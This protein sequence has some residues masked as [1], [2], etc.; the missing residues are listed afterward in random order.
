MSYADDGAGAPILLVHGWSAHGGFFENLAQRLGRSHRVLTLTLRAHPGSAQG[1]APLTIDTLADDIA[2]FVAGLDLRDTVALGWSMG[3]MALWAAMPRIGPRITALVVE[4]MGAT[5]VNDAAWSGGLAGGYQQSDVAAT[6][7]DA[8]TD[9]PAH[10]ARFAPKMFAPSVRRE[11]PDLVAWA[12][13]EMSAA[14]SEAMAC[15]WASMASQD[16]RT[17]L[18]A[19]KAP[20]LVVHGAASLIYSERAT[21]FVASAAPNCEHVVISGA[22]HV[23][24]LEA[25]DAFF[26]HV[27][28]FVRTTRRPE[29]KSGGVKS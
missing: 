23:P 22:G 8:R 3:A 14:N 10:V 12:T 25:P 19:I 26:H 7:A 16:F 1:S 4:D 11:K 17:A 29:L 5:L 21:Q 15:F 9:W 20:M 27:E 18:K 13:R 28:A 6:L 24:H 2:H